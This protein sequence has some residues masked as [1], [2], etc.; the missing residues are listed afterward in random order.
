MATGAEFYAAL[1]ALHERM[2]A[3]DPTLLGEVARLVFEP[4]IAQLRQ[5][6]R[7]VDDQLLHERAA[8]ALM[9][10]GRNPSQANA[11]TGAG[12]M[13]FLMLRSK[14]RVIDRIRKERRRD[15]AEGAYAHGLDPSV[16]QGRGKSVELRRAQPE[17]GAEGLSDAVSVPPP[18]VEE[19]LDQEA[20]IAWVLAGAK[21]DVD[22]R[23]LELM[24]AGVRETAE[25]AR[26]LGIGA[27]PVEVQEA[28]VKR[29][30][31]RL[32]AAA[33]RREEAKRSVPKRRG[34]PPRQRD[35]DGGDRG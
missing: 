22:R 11:T 14:S 20:Q 18:D 35:G 16:K 3:G 19:R 21:T 17:H 27:E 26:V 8:D 28:T 7:G 25:Y 32:L 12:V 34:R 1:F 15:V 2:L 33:K 30:K 10:Y 6:F 29:H 5:K 4:L 9:E 23:L 13:G 24:F 31:D